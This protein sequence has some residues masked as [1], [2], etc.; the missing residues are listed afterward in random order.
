ML[1]EFSGLTAHTQGREIRLVLKHEIG[2]ILSDVRRDSDAWCLARAAHILR[3]DILGVKNSFNGTFSSQR[4]TKSI[5]SSFL[6]LVGMLV[7]GPSTKIGPSDCLSITQLVVINITLSI[8]SEQH[9]PHRGAVAGGLGGGCPPCRKF[10]RKSRKIQN[11]SENFKYRTKCKVFVDP[12]QKVTYLF[13]TCRKIGHPQ[14]FLLILS[15]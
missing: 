15:D 1:K 2:G 9:T 4:K 8:R 3:R 11:L 13:G 7:K 5:A 12:V 10:C 14:P 6:S